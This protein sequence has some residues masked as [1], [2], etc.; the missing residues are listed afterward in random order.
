MAKDISEQK[1]T[2]FFHDRIEPLM[3]VYEDDMTAFGKLMYSLFQYSLYGE[4]V[5]L[6]DKRENAELKRLRSMVDIGRESTRSYRVN[7][8]IKSNLRYATSEDDMKNRLQ[9]AGFDDEEIR[10]GIDSYRQKRIKDAGITLDSNGQATSWDS[11]GL[12]N[13]DKGLYRR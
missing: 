9:S 11:A 8:T 7:Q 1:A 4:I 10:Q 5:D 3:E 6:G 2:T 12:L 13:G